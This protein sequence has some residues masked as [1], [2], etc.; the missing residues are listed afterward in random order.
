[1]R[2]HW[3]SNGGADR[4]ETGAQGFWGTGEEPMCS[5]EEDEFTGGGKNTS[6]AIDFGGSRSEIALPE[7]CEESG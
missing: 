4:F 7:D 2:K 1:L 6:F 5:F 3:E